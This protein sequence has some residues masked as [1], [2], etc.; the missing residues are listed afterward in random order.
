MAS[1]GASLAWARGLEWPGQ[2]SNATGFAVLG[3]SDRWHFVL[4]FS[5]ILSSVYWSC[6][7][8]FMG[9]DYF[10]L[11][12][13][14]R[15]NANDGTY[16]SRAAIREALV[17]AVVG[18]LL[19]RP[20]LL[21]VFFPVFVRLLGMGAGS[22]EMPGAWTVAWQFLACMQVDDFLFYWSHRLLHHRLIYK[23]IHKKHHDFRHS[24]A[25]GVEHAHPIEDLVSN[26]LSTIA[27]PLLLRSH[28]TVLFLYT[29]AKLWQSIDAHSGY[30]LPFPLSPWSAIKYMDCAPAHDFHHSHNH[31]NCE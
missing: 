11:L 29:G 26:T 5:A 27:G 14:Y 23:H 3:E 15:I 7:A 24:I 16:P 20:A 21:F 9:C 1:Y 18:Q 2:L 25:I 12:S 22:G 13:R 17:D 30:D 10:G 8:F 19:V 31:G 6:V 4:L 28:V